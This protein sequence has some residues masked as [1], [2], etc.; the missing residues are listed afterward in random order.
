MRGCHRFD[1]TLE[2]S[3]KANHRAAC[4]LRA[5]GD[6]RNKCKH[7]FYAVVE[8]GDE[9]ALVIFQFP[10]FGYI[11]ANDERHGPTVRVA[12]GTRR[13]SYPQDAPIA[14]NLANL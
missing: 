10:A 13:F 4:L 14:T 1:A 6:S 9:S 2:C 5:R 3:D 11:L 8:F 12:H 7:I